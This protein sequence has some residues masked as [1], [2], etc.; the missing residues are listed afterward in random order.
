MRV[1]TSS[2]TDGFLYQINQLQSQQTTLQGEA[3]TGLS[4][5]EPEQDPAVMNQVLNL[6]SEASA[7]AQYQNNIAQ[8]QNSAT[9]ASDALNSL[10]SLVEQAGEIATQANGLSS[11][12][13]LSSYATQVGQLIQQAL[14]IANTQDANGNY[15]FGGTETGTAPFSATTSANGDINSVAYSGNTSVADSEIAPGLTVSAQTPG[16]N[17]SG[18]G[19]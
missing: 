14:Q 19:A 18:S 1:S 5:T 12:T 16:E 13:Q 7:G 10:Q 15:I 6:Q 9:T 11:P 17:N 2:F 8:I 3:S 4:I